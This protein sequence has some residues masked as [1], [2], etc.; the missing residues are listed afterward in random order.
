M[1]SLHKQNIGYLYILPWIIG[2]LTFQIYPFFMSFY[3]SFT[4]FSMVREPVFIGLANY[5]EMFTRD[6]NYFG[7]VRVTLIYVFVGVP[8]KLAFALM[9]AVL[10][11][12]KFK[13]INLF[14]TLYYLPSILGG[15]VT[16][17]LLW[18]FLFSRSGVVNQFLGRFYIPPVDWLGSDRWALF[19]V[20]LLTVWQFGS[21]MV[22]FLAGLKQVPNELYEA[23]RVDGSGR[24]HS[25]LKITIPYLT[26]MILFNLIMQTIIAMQ[27][28]S[29]VW[30]ITGGGPLRATYLYG[31]MLYETGFIFLRMGYASAMTW[32]L[33]AII[34]LLT[35]LIFKTSSF[36][37]YYED[38]S[39]K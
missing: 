5:I 32:V 35:V 28:F 29:S 12:M 13:G 2:F 24:L 21:S 11:N 10:M 25:F 18:R 36:W 16:I 8:L 20:I 14:R 3:Y 26:P 23:A 4:N 37:V 31:I 1:R 30:N 39:K 17:A 6:R 9:V 22:I 19:T 34:M 38:G 33:F 15:S 7:S 27:Q